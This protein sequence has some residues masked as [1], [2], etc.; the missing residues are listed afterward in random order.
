MDMISLTI[1]EL[2]YLVL[3][4]FITIVGTLLIMVLVRVLKILGPI[5]EIANMYYKIKSIFGYYG[6]I[7]EMVK[8]KIMSII[9]KN[10]KEE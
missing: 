3:I 4:F 1:L 6:Q 9:S 10:N 2:L 8:E 7:P 5:T